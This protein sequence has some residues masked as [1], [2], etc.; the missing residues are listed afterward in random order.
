MAQDGKEI[1]YLR[2]RKAMTALFVALFIP[3]VY[4][5]LVHG[6]YEQIVLALF[7]LAVAI[8]GIWFFSAVAISNDGLVLYR[9]NRLRWEEVKSARKV[10]LLGLPYVLIKRHTGFTW[11]LPLYYEGKRDIREALRSVVPSGNPLKESIN[12]A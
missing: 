10:R 9:V 1:F 5:S 6:V 2:W 4:L 8:V 12:E 3:I 11:W 7:N